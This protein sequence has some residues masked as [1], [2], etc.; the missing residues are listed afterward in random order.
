MVGRSPPSL[1][2]L[3]LSLA[4]HS[5]FV[6]LTAGSANALGMGVGARLPDP[7]GL[8]PGS[9]PRG[10]EGCEGAP[11]VAGRRTSSDQRGRRDC[12][13]VAGV[14]SLSP[15]LPGSAQ[16]GDEGC[17]RAGESSPDLF[18]SAGGSKGARGREGG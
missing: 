8:C 9:T 6:P 4:N 17:M 15:S 3:W 16:G 7:A 2:V 13:G 1:N 10:K 11:P 5:P 18:G 14:L 12:N